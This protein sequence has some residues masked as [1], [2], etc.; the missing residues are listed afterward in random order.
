M[1]GLSG[2][3]NMFLGVV[4]SPLVV[5]A[6]LAS[7]SRAELFQ[8]MVL[9][10]ST[11]SGAILVLYA[12]TLRQTVDDAVGHM[13]AASLVSLPA[14]LLVARIMVPGAKGEAGHTCRSQR[15]GGRER[16]GTGPAL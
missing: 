11:I 4:E 16:P 6:Y 7:M 8:V 3:A 14:A 10:M 1:V 15:C 9:A 5:R 13:I 12:T 2:G